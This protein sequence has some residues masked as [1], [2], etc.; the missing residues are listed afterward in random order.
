MQR[1]MFLRIAHD[2]V[3][4]IE[5]NPRPPA[6]QIALLGENLDDAL[7]TTPPPSRAIPTARSDISLQ[8]QSAGNVARA[9]SPCQFVKNW[10][11]ERKNELAEDGDAS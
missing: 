3:M 6:Q 10:S 4:E 8:F 11:A 7:P 5:G 1:G 9:T 2:D